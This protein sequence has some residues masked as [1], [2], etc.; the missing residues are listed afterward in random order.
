MGSSK[1]AGR[2]LKMPSGRVREG[3]YVVILII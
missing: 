1:E 2:L 3:M